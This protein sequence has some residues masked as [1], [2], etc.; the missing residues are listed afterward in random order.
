MLPEDRKTLNQLKDE[1]NLL[2]SKKLKAEMLGK[3]DQC[4]E[5]QAKIEEHER[6]LEEFRSSLR[7]TER[8]PPKSVS[9]PE[10]P[11]KVDGDYASRLLDQC[12]K[13]MDELKS[14]QQGNPRRIPLDPSKVKRMNELN[15]LNVSINRGDHLAACPKECTLIS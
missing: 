13:E 1:L 14:R 10:K 15:L 4:N 12:R 6:K 2:S 5:Y 3:T 11:R 9:R 8:P 7:R